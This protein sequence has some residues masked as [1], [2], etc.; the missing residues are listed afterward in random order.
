MTAMVFLFAV[1]VIFVAVLLFEEQPAGAGASRRPRGLLTWLTAGNWPAKVGGGLL[2][3]GVGAL[4]RYAL[5]NFD[6][7][8]TIK[9]ALGVAIAGLLALASALIE[10]SPG[11][12]AESSAA[13]WRGD[14]IGDG[15]PRRAVSLALGGAAFGVAYLTAYGAFA[16]FHYLGDGNGLALL[17]L[18][19]IG[20]GVYAV[21]RGALS[22]ALLA[23]LG[24]FLAPA[25]ATD[26]PGPGVVYGYYA[27][28]S[29]L[30]LL[31]VALRGWRPLIHL[32]FL[33]TLGGGV[34]FAWTAHYFSAEHAAVM[35]PALLVLTALHVAMPIVERGGAQQHWLKSADMAFMLAL[36]VAA[37]FAAWCVAPS[38]LQR[39]NEL[40]GLGAI[41][42]AAALYLWLR[43]R[44][45]FALHLVIGVLL[46]GIGAAA[47]FEELPWELLAL[48]AVVIALA[49]ASR[50]S[51]S[52]RL[53]G[54]L[55]GLVPLFGILHIVSS[56][57][58]PHDSP[59]F[60][61]GPFLERLIGAGL[62][63]LA[64]FICRRIRQRLD[65]LLWSVGIAWALWA[66]GAELL[67]W[68]IA[69]IGI[70]IHWSL[71]LAAVAFGLISVRTA[72]ASIVA[73]LLP[74]AIAA[75]AQIAATE[76]TA[77]LRWTTL[78]AA[79]AALLWLALRGT[80]A[81][82]DTR[83]ARLMAAA[84]VPVVAG[85]WAAQAGMALQWLQPSFAL[86]VAA[87]AAL[88]TLVA[89]HLAPAHSRDWIKAVQE[90]SALAF[91]LVLFL[92]T[93]IAIGRSPWSVVLELTC[94]I[95]LI[96][97]VYSERSEAPLPAWVAPICALGMALVLQ[98]NLL[99][100]LGPPGDLDIA[101][102]ANMRSPSLVSL[103]W[104]ALGAA[105]TVWGRNSHS[106]TLWVAGAVLLAVAAVKLVLLDF[107]SLGQLTDIFAVIGAGLVFLLVGWFAPMPPK[108]PATAAAPTAA[109]VAAA[110]PARSE[111]SNNPLAWTIAILCG[112]VLPLTQC[113]HSA[114][115]FLRHG[116]GNAPSKQP[117]QITGHASG[118]TACAAKT[119][120]S[121]Q[122]RFIAG[123]SLV[124]TRTAQPAQ[125]PTA[126]AMN[127][128][129]DT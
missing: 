124:C 64:G 122:T 89:A 31:M 49:V 110:A 63:M 39:S 9:L 10:Q 76:A 45:E 17:V 107:G 38:M 127:S 14:S 69:S 88:L 129:S 26:D 101:D 128:S 58:P 86:S 51:D 97:L 6:V 4:L 7:A 117:Q 44:E 114:R 67:R 80:H 108:A 78:I 71:L 72:S 13:D 103:L 66:I 54:F 36:P 62:L 92:A 100:W 74:L 112:L 65:T 126:Q 27:A 60:A 55:C 35:L 84:L 32:S 79:P 68:D 59:V 33:F 109:G 119:G 42:L 11:S 90:L 93:V 34:L 28:A 37:A 111:Q 85:I 25:F 12:D 102:L 77:Q 121:T 98:A 30:T 41:W 22:L 2:V 15:L 46:T 125:P 23:M 123:P 48:L 29:L 113:N 83:A 24:A 82:P 116:W 8:A 94:L 50:R 96:W 16:L 40:L 18:T 81:N 5:L 87:D 75:S 1:A 70:L 56:Q 105:L 106:R 19:A 99:R 73:M 120:P 57:A 91:A 3:V 53:H 61:N 52:Q 43:Q 21:S 47:R 118:N 115:E 20:A 104:A 95:G